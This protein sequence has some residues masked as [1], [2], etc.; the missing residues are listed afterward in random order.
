MLHAGHDDH[1]PQE[2]RL[3]VGGGGPPAEGERPSDRAPGGPH[4]AGFLPRGAEDGLL[5]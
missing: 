5:P 4:R 3:R 2:E 1:V